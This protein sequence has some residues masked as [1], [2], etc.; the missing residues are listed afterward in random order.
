VPPIATGALI[1]SPRN[2]HA[3]TATESGSSTP[4]IPLRTAPI[5]RRLAIMHRNA[6]AVIAAIANTRS[7]A[8]WPLGTVHDVDTSA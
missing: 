4:M 8:R 3:S 2:A 6:P 5:R 7:G 1:G